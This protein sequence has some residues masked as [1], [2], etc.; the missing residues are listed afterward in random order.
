MIVTSLECLLIAGDLCV[1]VPARALFYR[2][3]NEIAQIDI[4]SSVIYNET[5]SDHQI[6]VST[7]TSQRICRRGRCMYVHSNCHTPLILNCRITY[8]YSND[9]YEKTVSIRLNPEDSRDILN[10][11]ALRIGRSNNFMKLG[12]L[13]NI[14]TGDHAC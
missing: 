6:S 7:I 13:L 12:D 8:F 2:G 3:L 9:L 5:A 14:V 11:V 10:N 1:T 4:G